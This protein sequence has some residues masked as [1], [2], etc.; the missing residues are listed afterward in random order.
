MLL[1]IATIVCGVLVPSIV[2]WF[3]VPFLV[4]NQRELAGLL[5]LVAVCMAE[6][7][8]DKS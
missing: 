7:F 8:Q 1:F 5:C 6:S 4:S 3:L 2:V